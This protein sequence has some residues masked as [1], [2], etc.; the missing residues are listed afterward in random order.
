MSKYAVFAAT[1]DGPVRIERITAEPAPQS[2]ICLGRTSEV[3][4]IS[5]GYDD[6]VR[7][8]SG[9]I[10]REFGPDE[11]DAFRLDI[12]GPISSGR[13]WQLAVFAA[14]A[15]RA[16]ENAELAPVE[17]AD[18]VL[19]LTGTVDYDLNVGPVD[20]VPQKIEA[21]RTLFAAWAERDIPVIAACAGAEDAEALRRAGLPGQVE[22]VALTTTTDLL[23]RLPLGPTDLRKAKETKTVTRSRRPFPWGFV[24]GSLVVAGALA[25]LWHK[26]SIE[27]DPGLPDTTPAAAIQLT[28]PRGENPTYHFGEKLDLKLTLGRDAWVNCFYHQADGSTLRILP[29]SRFPEAH[30]TGGRSYDLPGGNLFPFEL[31]VAAPAGEEKI[32]CYAA[33]RKIDSDLSDGLDNQLQGLAGT[34]IHAATLSLSVRP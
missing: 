5:G 4:S 1:T 31:E 33:D 9:V 29:N 25:F 13:S 30:L 12:S 11:E 26:P 10:L 34:Q 7:P 16:A 8:G 27:T 23:A 24:L 22:V 21:S 18:R 6:F 2:M 14:H 15:L 28:S 19:W 32:T 20:H 3:L 17:Q